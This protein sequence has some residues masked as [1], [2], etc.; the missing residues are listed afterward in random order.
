MFNIIIEIANTVSVYVYMVIHYV[1]EGEVFVSGGSLTLDGTLANLYNT[2][3]CHTIFTCK[4]CECMLI[5]CVMCC[6]ENLFMMKRGRSV[7]PDD[8][9]PHTRRARIV[10]SS[11]FLR[12]AARLC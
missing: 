6:D 3:H 5:C 11:N 8:S 9:A 12:C 10:C 7:S 4:Y 2:I 1:C